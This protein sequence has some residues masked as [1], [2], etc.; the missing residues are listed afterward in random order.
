MTESIMTV[1]VASCYFNLH[2]Y[3]TNI[4]ERANGVQCSSGLRVKRILKGG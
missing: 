3:Q 1:L 2:P 4:H